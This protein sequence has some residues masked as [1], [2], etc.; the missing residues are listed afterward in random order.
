MV[1]DSLQYDVM[2]E[3]ALRSV[4]RKALSS[5]A[6]N[7]L[8]GDHHFYVTFRTEFPGVTLPAH[9]KE[10]YPNEMTIVL[11]FQFWGLEVTEDYFTVTLSFNDKLER[12]VIPLAA[13]TAFADPSV[14]FGLQFD[15][16]EESEEDDEEPSEESAAVT[17]LSFDDRVEE[18]SEERG[19]ESPPG[20]PEDESE[21]RESAKVVTLDTFRKK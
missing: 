2:V 19:E 13:I 18:L 3:E 16:H 15:S 17:D 10:R 11:Q 5:A 12:L 1:D 9:L 21:E 6:Q 20:G 14:R 4:V 8:P 7:G